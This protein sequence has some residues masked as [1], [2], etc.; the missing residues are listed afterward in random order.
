MAFTQTL[1][2][3]IRELA[4]LRGKTAPETTHYAAFK[5]LLDAVGETLHPRVTAVIHVKDSG[6][7]IPDLALFNERQ[8]F[9]QKPEHG[10]V[11]VKAVREP[12]D[13]VARGKQVR[14][15]LDHYDQVLVTNFYQFVVVSRD[16]EGR[17]A[18]EERF[19]LAPDEASF[20]ASAAH[21]RRFA[22]E[23][24]A[25]LYEYLQRVLQRGV[26]LADPRDVARM[27]ASYARAAAAQIARWDAGSTA[28]AGIR[29]DFEEAL[30]I[31]FESMKADDGGRMD[32]DSFF[33]STLIQT[34]FYGIFASWV[35]WAEK[36]P[37]SDRGRFDLWRDTRRLPTPVMQDLFYQL[38]EPD[39]LEQ[40][41]I[42][43][44][45]L[46]MVDA[47]N[48]VKRAEFFATFGLNNAVQYFY[49]P[50]LEAFAPELRK[51]LGVW[52]TP[53]EIVDY[54]TARVDDALE[55]E[56]GV[57]GG[58]ANPDVVV[59]DPCC[60]TGAYLIAVLRRIHD[61]LTAQGETPFAIASALADAICERLY[62][63]EIL[64]A[65]FVVAHIQLHG[66]LR[67]FG[68]SLERGR[69][70]GVFLTNA[71]T[72]WSP[73]DAPPKQL[74]LQGLERERDAAEQVKRSGKILVILGNPPYNAF[75]GASPAE[76][77][78]MVDLYKA[79]LNTAW[80]IRKFNLDDLYIRFFRLAER[81]VTELSAEKRGIVCYIS[82]ASYLSDPSFVVMR[83]RFL[84]EFDR[85][86][87][88]NLNGD[89]RETGKRIPKGLPG[90]GLP[91]P[92]AFSTEYNR[93]GIR[94]GTAV[95]LMIRRPTRYPAP[96]V[97]Y[98]DLWGTSKRADL[99]ASLN[100]ADFDGQYATAAPTPEN[101]YTLRPRS[102]SDRYMTWSR[103][104]DLCAVP[105]MNGLMEKRGGAL[106]DIDRA[107]LE[108]RMRAYFDR[109][110]DWDAYRALGYGLTET[111]GRFDPRAA[112]QRAL[113]GEGFDV[114]N[115]VR[116]L[117]RPFE[118]RWCY[119][120]PIRPIWNEPR[121]G[122]YAQCWRGNQF[123]VTRRIGSAAD[124]GTP[125][126]FGGYLGDDHLLKVDAS[127]F[128]VMLRNG[129]SL[130]A[131]G[132]RA[133]Y[134]LLPA[135][136][137]AEV[138]PVAN[139]SPSARALLARLGFPDPDADFDSAALLWRHALAIGYAPAYLADHADGLKD[140][141]ARIPLPE[142]ADL[143]RA[144]A[145]LG[146]QV[147]DLLDTEGDS[148]GV[149]TGTI[150]PELRPVAAL[151]AA[152]G[153]VDL[154]VTAG[155]GRL[156]RGEVVMPGRGRTRAAEGRIDVYL[157][158]TTFWG[159][160]PEAAWGYTIGGYQVLKKWLSYR[161]QAILGRPLTADEAVEFTRI[162]RRL[163]A[164]VALEP[165]LDENYRAAAS[166]NEQSA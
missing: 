76:E 50:F 129:K 71:L 11:E 156:Q 10:V 53:T 9:D 31:H 36:T 64:T 2:A 73:A 134:E 142:D 116:Y 152:D 115:L 75:A 89:S 44:L 133:L 65:P 132:Q 47:L 135:D 57:V 144:S 105:P 124:E 101:R 138:R 52:Y 51:T 74:F 141:W 103:V 148:A 104:T 62:G 99:L 157:N 149:T 28:F 18:Y 140:D 58:L 69:R 95:G 6:A 163:T 108:R 112:R 17:P 159:G 70:P 88:D 136:A 158:E 59:L 5:R 39:R 145:A 67:S 78:G 56:L 97:R 120:T 126:Y 77:Q 122:L 161:E 66:L 93:E 87:F 60:G 107:A 48:R 130:T 153:A 54:M 37:A 92:S 147:A 79:G 82:N 96:T 4:T 27:M 14:R 123:F 137:A 43:S 55:R 94:Q 3:Y 110:L 160:I 127:Y 86:W 85:M 22:V 162:A 13:V 19:S 80:G 29:Q 15:Y 128:P 61:R 12:L 166:V 68:V 35:L 81:C 113:E 131:V 34:V 45:L 1:E 40:L 100:A 63:F 121:P 25:L 84:Q 49:E 125:F 155:W 154:A 20:W 26:E 33:R 8:E 106:I 7:G 164:L 41:G 118:T 114:R 111:Q 117:V 91:D 21:P 139:L 46:W 119:Y 98:R 32:G 143:L 72:G 90:E 83:R 109:D 151:T 24:D 150:R 38:T 165:A 146:R 16:D 23:Q 42:E 102:V 30:G